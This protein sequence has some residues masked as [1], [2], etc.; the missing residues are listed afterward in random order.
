MN[1]F[2]SLKRHGGLVFLIKKTKGVNY[3]RFFP[4]R[5]S[6]PSAVDTF[7]FVL[8]LTRSIGTRTGHM[9]PVANRLLPLQLG[10]SLLSLCFLFP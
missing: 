4:I 10:N 2:V 9:V 8:A 5:C 3:I 7:F 1:D 6:R